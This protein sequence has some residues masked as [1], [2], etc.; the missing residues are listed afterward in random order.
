MKRSFESL[1]AEAAERRIE[2]RVRPARD[3]QTGNLVLLP[4]W[5]SRWHCQSIFWPLAV[6]LCRL[7]R[8]SGY[9]QGNHFS[10][11]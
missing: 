2:L 3:P 4:N 8:M 7:S 5:L 10:H 6:W 11:G 9:D 1:L